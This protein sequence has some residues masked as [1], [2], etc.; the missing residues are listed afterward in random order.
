MVFESDHQLYE[1]IMTA[2]TS[3]EEEQW[4]ERL[5]RSSEQDQDSRDPEQYSHLSLDMRSM[6]PVFRKPGEHSDRHG[7]QQRNLTH[8]KERWLDGCRFIA[9]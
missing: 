2:C 7:L 5:H 8:G 3:Q 9:L 6:G 1:M 4:R